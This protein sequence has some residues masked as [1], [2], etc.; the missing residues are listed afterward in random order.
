M[1]S[2]PVAGIVEN[3]LQCEP[4][5]LLSEA[6]SGGPAPL[7]F[8]WFGW[9]WTAGPGLKSLRP[10]P[11]GH[12]L[13][14]AGAS[15]GSWFNGRSGLVTVA[16]L[17]KLVLLQCLHIASSHSHWHFLLARASVLGGV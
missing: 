15:A 17:P 11:A 12:L 7:F 10:P 5:K 4:G 1:A 6:A 9:V 16:P 2:T 8:V 14:L 3:I 13:T